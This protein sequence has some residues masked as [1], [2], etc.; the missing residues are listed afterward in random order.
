MK[1]L[2]PIVLLALGCLATSCGER[3]THAPPAGASTVATPAASYCLPASTAWAEDEYTQWMT[4]AELRFFHDQI[5]AGQYFAHVE[6]R[7]NAGLSEYRA[8]KKPLPSEQY[9]DASVSWGLDDNDAFT[10]E[11][12]LLRAGFVRK[13]M[14]V[15]IDASGSARL[16]IVWLRPAG[17]P[18]AA[19]AQPT[20]P[21]EAAVT[22]EP[23]PEP[24]V[25]TPGPTQ[26]ATT[27]AEPETAPSRAATPPPEDKPP[28]ATLVPR[29]DSQGPKNFTTYTV[30]KGDSVEKIA[31]RQHTTVDAIL[32]ANNMSND[33]LQ[34][35]QKLKIPRK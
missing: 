20:I 32:T 24:A 30:V 33:S 19:P 13:S 22:P 15:F 2:T 8:V 29:S 31:H 12:R 9:A 14:Q 35:G 23:E 5:P 16:Q 3:K 11:L 17:T 27:P 18:P 4:R 6:G 1:P 28:M 7:N 25:T 26:P 34:I 21:P 10:S